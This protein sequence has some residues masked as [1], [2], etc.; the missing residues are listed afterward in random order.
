MEKKIFIVGKDFPDGSEFANGA[1]NHKRRVAAT[2]S[3]QN[4]SEEMF[5]PANGVTTFPWNKAS[6]LSARSVVLA[7]LNS[8][9]SID[10]IVLFFDE[11]YYAKFFGEKTS[12]S[13]SIKILEEAIASYQY[14]VAELISKIRK[15]SEKSQKRESERKSVKLIFLHKDNYSL[16]DS[17]SGPH[18]VDGVFSSPL[19]SSAS[20]AFKAFSENMAAKIVD[21]ELFFPLLVNCE[22]GNDYQNRDSSLA[23]WLCDYLSALDTQKAQPSQKDKLTW[24]KA[25]AKKPGNGFS[26]F[27]R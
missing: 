5:A 13:D 16:C 12:N 21:D 14:L 22:I 6:A 20:A 8:F 18:P 26:F 19:V 1:A 17:L 11:P 10:E 23:G 24:I 25:G 2:N 4:D 9:V 15:E 27:G 3:V 7:V